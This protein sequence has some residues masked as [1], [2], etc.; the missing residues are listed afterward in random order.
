MTRAAVNVGTGVF[1]IEDDG[2]IAAN[3]TRTINEGAPQSLEIC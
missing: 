1:Q 3:I 2:P